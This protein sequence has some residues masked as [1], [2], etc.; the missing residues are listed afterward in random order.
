M[1]NLCLKSVGKASS[2]KLRRRWGTGNELG[3]VEMKCN[4]VYWV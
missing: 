4:N 3:H 2:G 1:Y